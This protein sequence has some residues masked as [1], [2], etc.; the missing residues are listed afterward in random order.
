MANEQQ[1]QATGKEE[2]PAAQHEQGAMAGRQGPQRERGLQRYR[3]G[4]WMS[5]F[6]E[7]DRLFDRFFPRGLMRSMRPG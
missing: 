5:P 4:P 6:E 3:A 1:E 7:L 2:Q